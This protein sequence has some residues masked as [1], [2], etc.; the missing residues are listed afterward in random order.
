MKNVC[1]VVDLSSAFDQINRELLFKSIEQ[2]FPNDDEK[3][4][5]SIINVIYSNTTT[6][7]AETPTDI[8]NG[9][10]KIAPH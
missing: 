8:F 2:R 1:M 5:F 6:A 9:V 10:R 3:T 4:L 7:L